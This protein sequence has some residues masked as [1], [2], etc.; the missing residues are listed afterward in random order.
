[1]QSGLDETALR[2]LLVAG[3]GLVSDFELD[4][5]L[6]DVLEAA[7][8]I[9]GAR[10]AA[11]GVLNADRSGLERFIHLGID[12]ATRERIGELPTGKGVLG[13]LI[14]D[15]RPLR[16]ADVG[17]DRH[18]YGFPP[19]HPPMSAFLGV[20]ITIRGEPWGNL[21]LT[22]K[23]GGE[24]FSAADE[25]AVVVLAD[26]A[27]IAIG[28]ARSVAA[29]RLRLSMDAAEQ[30]RLQW[31]RE[32]H[33]ETLQGLAAIRL[34]LATARRGAAGSLEDAVDRSL[35]QIDLE[36]ASLRS[37][38]TDLRPDSLDQLGI[39]TALSGLAARIRSRYPGVRVEVACTPAE[40]ERLELPPQIAI[41]RVA[42][43]AITNAI[44]HGG[45]GEIGVELERTADGAAADLRVRDDGCGFE[46]ER[47][48]LGFG[49]VGMQERASLARGELGIE[50][51]AGAGTTVTLTLPLRS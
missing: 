30:E 40:G 45:A 48:E 36:I 27:A 29:E 8:E 39:E 13:I 33:D 4:R 41:Y 19:G 26:W 51:A 23:A 25:E 15:P 7:T 49:I 38:I 34:I 43:E 35:E 18:S 9:T 50:S 2:R 3:R 14:E 37:L 1:M 28:N 21:Y 5:V 24:E 11:L 22:E 31:A 17:A 6:N 47:A 46:L 20:P 42:Q 44:R 16:L 10:Y 12:D 32:L